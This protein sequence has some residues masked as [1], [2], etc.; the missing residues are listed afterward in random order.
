MNVETK[1]DFILD[2]ILTKVQETEIN[3]EQAQNILDLM[4]NFKNLI[5][6]EV[7]KK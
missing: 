5:E 2:Q 4:E 6:K 7:E 1:V 3:K